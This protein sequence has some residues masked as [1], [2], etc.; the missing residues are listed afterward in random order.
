M[1]HIAN[2][3][4]YKTKKAFL[5][6]IKDNPSKV[7]VTDPSIIGSNS[8][9]IPDVLSRDHHI[10]VSNH[11]KRSWYAAVDLDNNIIKAS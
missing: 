2:P 5:A 8:G 6:A 7:Y 9:S 10:T 4:F 3:H 1:T 11:P